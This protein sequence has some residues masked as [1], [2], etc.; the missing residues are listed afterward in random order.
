MSGAEAWRLDAAA[1]EFYEERFVPAIFAGWAR[2]LV[3]E[4]SVQT[5]DRVLDVACGTGIVA[6]IAAE[7]TGE[8]GHV[9]GLDLNV[10]MIETA[11]RSE[12]ALAWC[13][14]EVNRAPFDAETFDVVLCQAALMFFPDRGSALREMWRML[15]P[16]GTLALQV[17]GESEGYERAAGV[18]ENV[19]G[20]EE[21]AIF[22]APFSLRDPDELVGLMRQAGIPGTRLTTHH[23]AAEYR[24]LEDFVRTEID[25]WVLRG[26]V[27]VD[28]ML[29]GARDAL[30]SRVADDGS[31]SIPME[32]HVVTASKG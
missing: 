4:A 32:G 27:D 6:R 17:F 14:G 18:I 30:A 22:R 29:K 8:P 10:S 3:D 11:R 12:P 5:G 1:A 23:R 24:S 21:A 26:R 2:R 15:R 16:K 31:I 13:V 19:A 7:R 20:E 9:V 28:A 25:G